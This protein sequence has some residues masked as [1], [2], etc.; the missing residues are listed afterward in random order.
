MG[1]RQPPTLM[2]VHETTS[3]QGNLRRLP[4]AAV[5][6]LSDLTDHECSADHWLATAVL[7]SPFHRGEKQ[8]SKVKAK[9]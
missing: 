2:K 6:N 8:Q 4:R 3:F 5:A 7:E 1:P 9:T